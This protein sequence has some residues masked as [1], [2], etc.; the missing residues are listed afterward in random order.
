MESLSGEQF[1]ARVISD[2]SFGVHNQVMSVLEQGA[3]C[4]NK[5]LTREKEKAS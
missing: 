3:M 4:S 5:E 2:E 1:Y